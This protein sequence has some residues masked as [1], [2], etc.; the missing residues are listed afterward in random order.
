MKIKW[1]LITLFVLSL[2]GSPALAGRLEKVESGVMGDL[3]GV[4][5]HPTDD[6]GVVGGDGVYKC[7]D[8]GSGYT[9]DMFFMSP[10]VLC[11]AVPAST[12]YSNQTRGSL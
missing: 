4:A 5:W 1:F 12:R 2:A 3:N 8:T 9:L 6:F 11:T 10:P 7:Y